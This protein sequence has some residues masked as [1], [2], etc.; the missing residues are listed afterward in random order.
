MIFLIFF[1]AV[2]N[3]DLLIISSFNENGGFIW[4]DK[5][6]NVKKKTQYFFPGVP[7]RYPGGAEIGKSSLRKK[8]FSLIFKIFR[9]FGQL[10]TYGSQRLLNSMRSPS[11]F[12][13]LSSWNARIRGLRFKIE[14]KL[15]AACL[16][17]WGFCEFSVLRF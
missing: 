15:G 12:E 9:I 2:E 14:E 17:L 3:F 16:R 13:E 5:E 1:D 6:K 10:Q 11:G 7:G 4:L 8:I